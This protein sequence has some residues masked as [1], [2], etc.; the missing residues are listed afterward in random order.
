MCEGKVGC[1]RGRWGACGEGGVCELR[2]S[3]L[4]KTGP[5]PLGGCCCCFVCCSVRGCTLTSSL[6]EY[7]PSESAEFNCMSENDSPN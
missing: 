6:L 4:L 3:Y 7:S 5:N 1:V 2:G